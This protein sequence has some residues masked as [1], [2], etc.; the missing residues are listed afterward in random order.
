MLRLTNLAVPLD[1]DDAF[2]RSLIEKKCG[3]S[4]GQLLS[5]TVIRRSVD[6][7]DK[8]NVH[9]VMSLDL[10]VRNEQLLLKKCRFLSPVPGSFLPAP[11]A[12]RFSSPPLVVGAGPAGLFAALTLARA[13]AAPVLVERGHSVEARSRDVEE[14]SLEGRL[15]PESNVQF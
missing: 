5:F 15:D 2:L 4:P 13:G 8:K 14:M 9:F 7:R 3:L 12:A 10:K 11:P 6:A 1:A